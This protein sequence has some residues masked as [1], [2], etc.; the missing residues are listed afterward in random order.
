MPK[1]WSEDHHGVPYAR[2]VGRMREYVIAIR[3]AWSATPEAPA[4][5]EG[6]FYRFTGYAPLAPPTPHRIPITLGVIRP[7]MTRLAG[8]IADGVQI[9]SMHSVQWTKDVM[10][11][12]IDEG[13]ARGGRSRSD[14]E[15]GVASS[16][17]STTTRRAPA[18]WRG[19]RSASTC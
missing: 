7:M 14:F 12:K 8:E 1:H 6:E 4:D 13:L 10:L 5:F 3:T 18:T 11:P 9:D 2:I 17:R 15:L 19:G 16:A